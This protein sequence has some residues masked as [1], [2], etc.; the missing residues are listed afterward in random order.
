MGS[1]VST[2]CIVRC[3]DNSLLRTMATTASLSSSNAPEHVKRHVRLLT[4]SVAANESE[5]RE[6]LSEEQWPSSADLDTL[7]QALVKVATKGSLKILRLLL[8][9]GAD[10]HPKKDNELS[11]LFKAAEAGHL[12]I[13]LELLDHHADPNWQ[14]A[15][16]AVA[17]QS[18]LFKAAEA[19]HLAVVTTLLARGAD[20]NLRAKNG[21]TALYLACLRGRNAVVKA[22]LDGGADPD[23]GRGKDG[24]VG[25]RDGRT[26]L[27]LISAEKLPEDKISEEKQQPAQKNSAE[28]LH[29]DMTRRRKKDPAKKAPTEKPISRWSTDTIK[30]LLSK[31]ANRNARDLTKRSPLHWAATNGYAELARCLLSGEP[32]EAADINAIQN[33][34]K[35]ALHLASEHNR[36]E[37]L[38]I[39]LEHG[40]SVDSRSD[41]RWT[42]L[43]NAAEKGH[44]TVVAKLLKAGADVN[45]GLSSHMTALHWASFNGHEDVVRL[46]LERSDINLSR[47][48]QFE[49]TPMLCAAER[50]H[51]GIVQMLSPMRHAHRLSKTAREA[52]KQ[53]KAT[54]VDFGELQYEKYQKNEVKEKKPQLV[55]THTVYDLLY[56]F[57]E[58][59]GQATVPVLTK[60][61]KWQP[62]FRWIHLPSNNIAWIEALL[63]KFFIEGGHRDVEGFKALGKC[64]DQE[65]R[66]PLAHANFMRPFCHHVPSR[67]AEKEDSSLGSV[68][69]QGSE[70][71]TLASQFTLAGTESIATDHSENSTGKP[72]EGRKK[73]KS[74]Q[75]AERHP[76]RP[77]RN[78]G[79]PGNPP[80]TKDARLSSRQSSFAPSLASTEAFRQLVNNGKMVLFVSFCLFFSATLRVASDVTML[81]A[82]PPLRD[83]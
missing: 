60:N 82:F 56:G 12:A 9:S 52:T 51:N 69:E 65:H 2:S 63:A 6:L 10:V 64:F 42:P 50:R 83:S 30:L 17:G 44:A 73:G 25:D 48:D 31:G 71:D 23:G 28:N 58:K 78:K 20:P 80:G 11:P 24:K 54:V 57:D 39:L 4:A 46:L 34:S 5:V 79:P 77:K 55:F 67:R 45:A 16:T 21:Q 70:R 53:F 1:I 13:V 36:I 22:L 41:G 74:E 27:L 15:K 76:Q 14:V 59:T 26:P 81:D 18:A 37:V 8:D 68:P 43:I 7:R 62:Q 38:V 49:R 66:G 40:A 47:K 72:A 75:I 33:R 61:I 29:E 3:I 19:G 32:W 35:T